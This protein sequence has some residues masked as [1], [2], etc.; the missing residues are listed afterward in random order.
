MK[1]FNQVFL[2]VVLSFL[3]VANISLQCKGQSNQAAR[4]NY[5][6]QLAQRWAWANESWTGDDGP[7]RII[8]SEIDQAITGNDDLE[9]LLTQYKSLA[10][11]K[12]TDPQ[13]QFR[14][15]YLGYR[16]SLLPKNLDNGISKIGLSLDAMEYAPSPHSYLYDRLRYQAMHLITSDYHMQKLGL[17]LLKCEPENRQILLDLVHDLSNNGD[18]IDRSK[19]QV[20]ADQSRALALAKQYVNHY[21]EDPEG[22]S[23]L[24]LIY[25]LIYLSNN[26][27]TD[28]SKSVAAFNEEL[29]HTSPD[30]IHYQV[31]QFLIKKVQSGLVK[32]NGQY[33][34]RETMSR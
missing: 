6:N 8:M 29:K 3:W 27:P 23:A 1:I 18:D 2:L 11:K 5:S 20:L 16:M 31:A 10:G 13:S 32:Y 25:S 24:G 22:Y 34:Y 7:Y 28:Q 21:P 9:Q 26:S 14:W 33:I 17:R 12:R 15:A 19:A 30:S 4:Q